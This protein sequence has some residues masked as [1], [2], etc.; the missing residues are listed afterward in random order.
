MRL[1]ERPFQMLSLGC[2]LVGLLP[3]L[4]GLLSALL[5]FSVIPG[6]AY[7]VRSLRRRAGAV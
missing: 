5:P 1:S 7:I 4:R 3:V 6:P 2:F